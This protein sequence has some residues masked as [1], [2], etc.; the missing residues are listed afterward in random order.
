MANDDKSHIAA[1]WEVGMFKP[2]DIV[3]VAVELFTSMVTAL[4][5]IFSQ[6]PSWRVLAV[7]AVFCLALLLLWMVSLMYRCIW[8]VIKTWADIKQL[9]ISAAQLAI[10]FTRGS[11]PPEAP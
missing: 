4:W 10:S 6:E 5:Y 7:V 8:F 1:L 3:I 9:P 11:G 2:Y